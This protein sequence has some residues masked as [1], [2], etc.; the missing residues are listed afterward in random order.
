MPEIYGTTCFPIEHAQL[1]I[2]ASAESGVT[3][4]LATEDGGVGRSRPP[5]FSGFVSPELADQLRAAAD[6]VDQITAA[7]A[8]QDGEGGQ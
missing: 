6:H 8:A 4:V 1:R 2:Q 3:F 7:M 5:L